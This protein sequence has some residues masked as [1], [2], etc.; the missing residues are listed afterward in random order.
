MTDIL[1]AVV[2]GAVATA[3]AIVVR[4]VWMTDAG[5][6]PAA[7]FTAAAFAFWQGSQR[8]HAKEIP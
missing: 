3:A 8:W 7:V 1:W 2:Y 4:A 6:G 5:W